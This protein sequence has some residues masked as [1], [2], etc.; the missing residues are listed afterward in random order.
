MTAILARRTARMAG[1]VFIVLGAGV[2]FASLLA[3]LVELRREPVDSPMLQI[4]LS[5]AVAVC[6]VL[7]VRWGRQT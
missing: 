5:F 3:P 1:N 7:L 6:G 4:L 2:G